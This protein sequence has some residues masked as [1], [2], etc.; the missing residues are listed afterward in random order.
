MKCTIFLR[1][2]ELHV[3]MADLVALAVSIGNLGM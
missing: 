2:E 1:L 3:I